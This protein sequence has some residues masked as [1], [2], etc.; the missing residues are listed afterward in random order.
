MKRNVM[1]TST[2]GFFSMK[3]DD[4]LQKSKMREAKV[5]IGLL[6]N[7]EIRSVKIKQQDEQFSNFLVRM[8]EKEV[9][10][11]QKLKA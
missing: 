1:R 9:E 7:E 4:Q 8:Q 10:V 11:K 6:R 5:M 2:S 3:A